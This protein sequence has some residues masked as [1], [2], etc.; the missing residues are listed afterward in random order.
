MV[1][2]FL[3]EV[4][5]RVLG[6]GPLSIP[7]Y[8]M[9]SDPPGVII[10]DSILQFRLQN[11]QYD[12]TINN[13][14]FYSTTHINGNRTSG[15]AMNSCDSLILIDFYGCSFTYGQGINDS[16]TFPYMLNE[17]FNNICINNYA[18][19]SY[20]TIHSLIQLENNLQANYIKPSYVIYFYN[21]FHQ[22]R[23]ILDFSREQN[24]LL[25]LK[26]NMTNLEFQ[27][28][29]S[30]IKIPYGKIKND[31]LFIKHKHLFDLKQDI[32]TFQQKSAI[33]NILFNNIYSS[34]DNATLVTIKAIERMHEKCN[35]NNIKFILASMSKIENDSVLEFF[36]HKNLP[37]IDMSISLD[38]D[39]YRNLPY[40]SHPSVLANKDY[41]KILAEYFEKELKLNT[42]KPKLH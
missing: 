26:N 39:G 13:A 11:G 16:F 27:K 42:T 30:K 34:K 4:I 36:I 40:D 10:P 2:V 12:V 21:D 35:S 14:L 33:L 20:G 37:I 9:N 8:T 32:I 19:P 22:K 17:G 3:I 1:I 38:Q 7:K 23:N 18:V 6:Y 5:L 29:L 25:G 24:F 41:A 31:T 28:L 15:K